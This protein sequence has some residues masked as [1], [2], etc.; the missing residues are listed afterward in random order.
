MLKESEF[1]YEPLTNYIN[2]FSENACFP[3]SLKKQTLLS[4][5]KMTTQ[6]I[7]LTKDL[8]AFYL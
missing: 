1:T 5:S 4:F 8:L 7:N 6:L 3:G 2:K